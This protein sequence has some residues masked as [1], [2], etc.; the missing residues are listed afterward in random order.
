[1]EKQ[2]KII[3]GLGLTGVAAYLFFK[4]KNLPSKNVIY[5]AS[6]ESYSDA[7]AKTKATSQPKV[8]V[9]APKRMDSVEILFRGT[10]LPVSTELIGRTFGEKPKKWWQKL[11]S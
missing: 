1:M 11:F 4:P 8:K 6:G 2:T 10:V 3:L 9:V 7:N 5:N